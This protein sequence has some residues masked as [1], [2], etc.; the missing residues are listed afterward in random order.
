M[1]EKTCKLIIIF[2]NVA[3]VLV[4][5]RNTT[6]AENN[7]TEKEKIEVLEKVL[8]KVTIQDSRIKTIESTLAKTNSELARLESKKDK[9]IIDKGNILE[10]LKMLDSKIIKTDSYSKKI[11]LLE[12]QIKKLTNNTNS[13]GT[14]N[15]VLS[16]TKDFKIN[17]IY[18][19]DRLFYEH[20]II[21][22][23]YKYKLNSAVWDGIAYENADQTFHNQKGIK[24]HESIKSYNDFKASNQSIQDSSMMLV[25]DPKVIEFWVHL[26]RIDN[27]FTSFKGTAIISYEK[28]IEEN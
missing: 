18:G 10:T 7:Y 24:Y 2:I 17:R 6:Y 25:D 13:W 19:M 5:L 23:G 15:K 8:E 22:K 12:E 4:I 16:L 28:I 1:G 11:Q 27:K 21:P 14:T 9:D 20:F 26:I 3:I